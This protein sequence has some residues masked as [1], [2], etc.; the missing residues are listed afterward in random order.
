MVLRSVGAMYE[1]RPENDGEEMACFVVR[2]YRSRYEWRSIGVTGL[3]TRYAGDH[4][5]IVAGL[6]EAACQ[7]QQQER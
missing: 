5:R 2:K 7:K 3:R 6:K 1:G 4:F